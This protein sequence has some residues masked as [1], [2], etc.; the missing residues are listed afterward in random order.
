M[1]LPESQ[2]T[3]KGIYV[4]IEIRSSIDEL[5]A[6]TQ[7]P[8]LHQR[9]DLRFTEI[10]YLPRPNLSEP[11][12]FLYSTRIGFG[13][14][15]SGRG[16]TLGTQE[17]DGS[18][19]SALKFW[20]D[21]PKSLIREGSGYWKYIPTQEGIRFLTWYDYATRFGALGRAVD[22]IV[23]RPLLGWAT[24][25]SFDRLRLWLDNRID[26]AASMRQSV[27]YAICRLTVA[28]VWLYQGLVPK[29]LFANLDEGAMLADAGWSAESINAAVRWAGIAE[30]AF[31]VLL[32]LA[33]RVRTLFAMTIVLMLAAIAFVGVES[34]RY[35]S[36]PF[37]PVTL[38]LSMVA[39]S[40]IGLLSRIDLPSASR[41]LRRRG[42]R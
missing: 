5:W 7:V 2:Q 35:L 15:I 34:P 37:N 20:S 8:E 36:A 41:C 24:A 31:G 10:E 16:E 4:E 6:K 13:M 18:T 17:Q 23:F 38:N 14:K 21:D 11:Q 33:W 9:W 1:K 26:P 3:A 27:V 28:F 39:L 25:W 22:S 42:S 40:V 12:Q 19:T 30:I 32:I 29:L